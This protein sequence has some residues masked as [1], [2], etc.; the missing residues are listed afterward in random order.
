VLTTVVT[1]FITTK[2]IKRYN[3]III[4]IRISD[5]NTLSAITLSKNNFQIKKGDYTTGTYSLTDNRKFDTI[6]LICGDNRF[7]VIPEWFT[8][9]GKLKNLFI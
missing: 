6:V 2:A 9:N 5:I 4:E 7:E 1:Y 3:N 8:D